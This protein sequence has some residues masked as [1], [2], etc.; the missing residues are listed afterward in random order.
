M[1]M[2]RVFFEQDGESEREDGA[3]ICVQQQDDGAKVAEREGLS[4]RRPPAWHDEDDE[5]IRCVNHSSISVTLLHWNSLQCG[6]LC[7]PEIKK[8]TE[9]GR[10]N[11]CLWNNLSATA[12]NTVNIKELIDVSHSYS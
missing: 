7:S 10:G 12:Q 3:A 4:S 9:S 11:Y 1:N 6:Y 5:D 2:C 8:V